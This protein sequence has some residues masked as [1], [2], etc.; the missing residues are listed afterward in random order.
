[1]DLLT[2]PYYNELKIKSVYNPLVEY[3]WNFWN[4]IKNSLN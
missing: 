1:M 4:K 3:V 2:Y